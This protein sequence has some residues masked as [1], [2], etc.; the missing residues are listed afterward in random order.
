[1]K[2]DLTTMRLSEPGDRTVLAELHAE[3]WRYAYRGIIPGLTLERMIARRGPA[4]WHSL[5]GS[6]RRALLIEFDGRIV[7]YAMFGRCRMR[8][9]PPLGE[10]YE[11]YVKPECHGAAFG[12]TLFE[13]AR[14]RLRERH[15]TGLRVWALAENDLACGFYKA[16]GGE[17][18]FRT[19]ETL[20]GV[21]LEKIAFH[22]G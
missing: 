11:L 6:G 10:V 3:A 12:R 2:A 21:R 17:A 4:W 19:S 22:W 16:L 14:R 1:V 5:C 13:E 15:L 20:G 7:G 8:S 9:R 18:R